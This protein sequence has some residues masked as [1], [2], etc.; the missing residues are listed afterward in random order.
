M[1]LHNRDAQGDWMTVTVAGD[2]LTGA[3]AV[4]RLVEDRL[5]LFQ[6]EWW[7]DPRVGN[8]VLEMFRTRRPTEMLLTQMTNMIAAYIQET[9][10]VLSVEDVQASVLN[11]EIAF[12]CRVMAAEGETFVSSWLQGP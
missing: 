2:G 8:L 7:E 11:R 6:T 3:E 4:A 1:L 12:S 5:K 10:G 9:D